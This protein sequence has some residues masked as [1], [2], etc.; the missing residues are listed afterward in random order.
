[1]G[2]GAETLTLDSMA[3]V[4]A[5]ELDD[6][7]TCYTSAPYAVS[8]ILPVWSSHH[9]T[10]ISGI[11]LGPCGDARSFNGVGLGVAT[12]YTINPPNI[13]PAVSSSATTLFNVPGS[14]HVAHDG[15]EGECRFLRHLSANV[16]SWFVEQPSISSSTHEHHFASDLHST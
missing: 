4:L 2:L 15:K 6:L 8:R 16:N 11:V 5:R 7:S 12:W 14:N 10:S 13:I 9:L 1:M 3:I